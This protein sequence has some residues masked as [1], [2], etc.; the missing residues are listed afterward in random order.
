MDTI[1]SLQEL[2]IM[3]SEEYSGQVIMVHESISVDLK[4]GVTWGQ[5]DVLIIITMADLA[6]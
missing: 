1:K 4:V 2:V 5:A 6:I 3:E